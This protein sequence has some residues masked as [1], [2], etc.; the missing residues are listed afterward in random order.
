MST[1]WVSQYIENLRGAFLADTFVADDAFH[2]A[3]RVLRGRRRLHAVAHGK[4]HAEAFAAV[5]DSDEFRA[6]GAVA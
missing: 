3:L 1:L 2:A 6:L 4:H 5:E